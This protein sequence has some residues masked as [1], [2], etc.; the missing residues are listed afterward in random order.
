MNLKRKQN[1]VNDAILKDIIEKLDRLKYGCVQITVHNG[2]IIQ[3]DKT[4]KTRFD[5]V[6]YVEI[7]SK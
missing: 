5:E 6:W 4:E 1:I 7:M 2:K 3:I